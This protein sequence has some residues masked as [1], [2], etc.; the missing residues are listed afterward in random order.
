[1][2]PLDAGFAFDD[3]VV[4][5]FVFVFVG[6]RVGPGLALADRDD[7]VVAFVGGASVG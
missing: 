1:L 4:F 2:T 6:V 5:G 3:V 7:E